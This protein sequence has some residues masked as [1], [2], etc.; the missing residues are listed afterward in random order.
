MDEHLIQA[1]PPEPALELTRTEKSHPINTRMG[2][3]GAAGGLL[4]LEVKFHRG[5]QR[6]EK[7]FESCGHS[8][9][10]ATPK[11]K[12]MPALFQL[13]EAVTPFLACQF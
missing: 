13:Q 3:P 6:Q 5:K 1:K 4:H 10:P 7:G 9:N 12:N 2:K 11:T 8:L